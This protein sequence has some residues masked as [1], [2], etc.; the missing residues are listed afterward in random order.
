MRQQENNRAVY[1]CK[2]EITFLGTAL[3]IHFHAQLIKAQ[4]GNVALVTFPVLWRQTEGHVAWIPYLAICILS[5]SGI[6]MTTDVAS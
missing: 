1:F 2:C 5:G 3:P 4:Q 6:A